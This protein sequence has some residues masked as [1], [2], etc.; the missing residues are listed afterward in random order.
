MTQTNATPGAPGPI[1]IAIHGGAGTIERDE[2]SNELDA[3]IRSALSEAARAGFDVLENG[4]AAVDAVTAAIGILEDAPE[5]NA[6]RGAVLTHQ[7]RVEMDASIMTGHDLQAGAVAGVH[8]IRHPILAAVDVLNN[9]PHVML[10]GR[11]AE[12]FAH[13]HG[14]Q[15]MPEEWFVTEFRRE[16][17]REAL[18]SE[19]SQASVDRGHYDRWY[20]TVGTVAL[21]R[22]GNLAAGTS[23]GGMTNKRFGRIGDSP[24]IGAGTYA[25]NRSCAVSATGHGEFFIRHVVAY[26]ICA[27]MLYGKQSLV[28][29]SETVINKVLV[30]AGGDGG[31]IALDAD[32]NIHMPFNTEGMY[33]A[34]IDR[35]GKLEIKIYGDE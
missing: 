4:G 6:G 23:T 5:F 30:E 29:A 11:G 3:A 32:G 25:D 26:D 17:L 34:S 16:Q 1:A 10:A 24:I 28:E 35:D 21:D 31:V 18:A 20:S 19:S 9:S 13:A 8:G 33:R 7:G 14:L 12:T 27:R 2:L 22:Q 15:F